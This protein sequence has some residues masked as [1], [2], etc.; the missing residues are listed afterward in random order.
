MSVCQ[1]TAEGVA[2]M[3]NVNVIH[4]MDSCEISSSDCTIHWYTKTFK[5]TYKQK[6]KF[7]EAA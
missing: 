3:L 7:M 2:I 1:W 6:D 4:G 5:F